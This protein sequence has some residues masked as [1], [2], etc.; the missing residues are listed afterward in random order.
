MP[1]KSYLMSL[2]SPTAIVQYAVSNLG[3]K[4]RLKYIKRLSDG[5][6]VVCFCKE[7]DTE[8]NGSATTRKEAMANAISAEFPVE[9]YP[10]PE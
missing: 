8:F 6:A 9:T 1:S 7:D 10:D 4:S 3:I 2:E 5:S